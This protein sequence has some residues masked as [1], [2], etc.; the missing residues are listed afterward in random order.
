MKPAKHKSYSEH[1]CF[2]Y[3]NPRFRI[4]YSLQDEME[5]RGYIELYVTGFR[6]FLPAELIH[7]PQ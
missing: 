6:H 4:I 2:Q 3:H 5:P 1:A 7:L